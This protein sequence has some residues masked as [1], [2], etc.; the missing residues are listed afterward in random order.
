M[1]SEIIDVAAISIADSKVLF[2][3]NIWIIINGFCGSSPGRKLSAY[4]N[5]YKQL[6]QKN[7][8]IIVNDYVL[9]EFSNRCARFEWELAK[10]NDPAVG[11]FKSYRQSPQFLPKMEL[12]RDTCL[13]IVSDC[14]YVRV[15]R[16]ECDIVQVIKDF[17]LG[18]L[19][20]S[21]LVLTQHCVHE[22]FYLMTDDGD[23]CDSGL[24]LITA[25][26]SLIKN[27]KAKAKPKTN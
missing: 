12:V 2:D 7:N 15:G 19:D 23:F 20:F 5:A 3:T 1:T 10:K 8:K 11:T 26:Q 21:D 17:C 14:E 27:V 13:S 9:G 18:K 6:L 16:T 25:N 22:N 24:R 4:S